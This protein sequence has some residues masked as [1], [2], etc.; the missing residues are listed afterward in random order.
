MKKVVMLIA[1]ILGTSVMATANTIPVKANASKE[2]KATVL[3][4]HKI[5]KRAKTVKVAPAKSLSQPA[6]K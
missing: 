1:V 3:R 2:V 5:A 4:K 6:K